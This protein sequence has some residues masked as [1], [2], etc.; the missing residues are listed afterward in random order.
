MSLDEDKNQSEEAA[1]V[2]ATN[3]DVRLDEATAANS[4]PAKSHINQCTCNFELE[5]KG[6]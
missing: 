4:C 6:E 2:E 5:L 1:A 3:R